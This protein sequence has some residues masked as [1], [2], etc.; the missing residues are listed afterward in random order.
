MLQVIGWSFPTQHF[1]ASPLPGLAGLSLDPNC[2]HLGVLHAEVVNLESNYAPVRFLDLQN[3]PVDAWILGHIHKPTVFAG[4]KLIRYPGS[5][6]SLSAKEQGVH[7]GF[8]FTIEE[9][10]ITR[11]E[12][13]VISTCR[14]ER[15]QVDVS[16]VDSKGSFRGLMGTE[17]SA[18][19][20][21]FLEQLEGAL[22]L[23]YDIELTGRNN[24]RQELQQ[25]LDELRHE[26]EGVMATGTKVLIRTAYLNIRPA[27]S[28]LE[29]LAGERSL[30]G[31]L[32]QTILA[33][34][35]GSSTPFLEQLISQWDTK[36][37]QI[38]YSNV[39]EPLQMGFQQNGNTRTAREFIE[40]ECNRLLGELLFPAN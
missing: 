14:F 10:R 38:T 16:S 12:E 37:R 11:V 34:R 18:H 7:G 21:S 31:L 35:E 20:N 33:L 9:R 29:T 5:C 8:M 3:A 39:F 40:E 19:A 2:F 26:Y 28:N 27:V 6:Q 36:F 13:V 1:P 22:F 32:A 23:V 15:L 30:V 25:W 17:L 4:D 24:R